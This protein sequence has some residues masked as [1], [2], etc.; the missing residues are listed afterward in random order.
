MSSSLYCYY[1]YKN[2]QNNDNTWLTNRRKGRNNFMFKKEILESIKE[3]DT[4]IIHRHVRPDPDAY[5]SQSGLAEII[6]STYPKKS[7]Y[8]VGEADPSLRF[9]AELDQIED[10]TFEGALVIVCDTANQERICDQRYTKGKKVIKIDHHPN[11]DPY[12]DITWVNTDASSTSEMIY[13]LFR[14][15]KKE[16]G[17]VLSN[18]GARLLF[19]GIVGDTGRFLFPSASATTFQYAS[20]LVKYNF[21]RTALYDNLYNTKHSIA[22]LKGYILQNFTVSS[23]GLSTIKITKETLQEF[24]LTSRETSQLVGVLGDIEGIIAWVFF[25]EEEDAIRVRLR[26]RGPIIN[27][28]AQK[29]NGGGHPLAS[30]ATVYS[31]EETDEVVK[32]LED[33]CFQYQQK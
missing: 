33:V 6:R 11:H 7:V 23:N 29:Y 31:W 26:S 4:I 24:G 18:E 27:I 16:Y 22:K 17:L 32:D 13:E 28:V 9:L 19:A 30:G 20:E 1:R 14:Y 15:G 10:E 2:E 3:F 8:V 21:D 12:G 25:I 5:G